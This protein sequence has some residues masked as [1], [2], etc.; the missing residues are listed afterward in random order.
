MEEPEIALPPHTQ[1]RIAKYLLNE[2]TQ[3]FV[4]TH[5]P[6]VIERFQPENIQ[7]LARDEHANVTATGLLV[8]LV[9][10][11]KMYRRHCRRG[12][13]EA[14][15]GQAVII[16]EGISEHTALLAVAERM[17]AE[18]EE[19]YPL[20]LSGV[21]VFTADGDGLL[22]PFG[23][24]FK[25]LGLK[26]YG[27]YDNKKRTPEGI[28]QFLDSFDLPCQTAYAGIEKLL[29]SETPLDRQWQFLSSLRQS[30]EQGSLGIP[31]SRPS[32]SE[33]R[34]L[35]TN[36][37]KSN[38]GNGHAAALIDCCEFSELPQTIVGFLK[39]VFSDFP[40][41]TH[42]PVP[43]PASQPS[44]DGAAPPRADSPAEL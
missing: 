10:K 12:L 26:T 16:T 9:I 20:D 5:S 11:G 40:P 21:T 14:M 31:A 13:A 27:F 23:A 28:Q 32:D 7:I 17:E 22:P 34:E 36:A 43:P 41:P 3:C 30:G 24:F 35:M 2:T 37:L 38:K 33:L 15:L 8:G 6:Y 19:Y 4:T 25:A 39:S 44:Q 42:V 18:N 29:A 1:R